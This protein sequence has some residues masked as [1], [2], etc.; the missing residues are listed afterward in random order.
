MTNGNV[1][2][3]TGIRVRQE[4]KVKKN[5]M[6]GIM[7]NITMNNKKKITAVVRSSL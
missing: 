7:K 2:V 1:N 3:K 4:F 6:L 5:K